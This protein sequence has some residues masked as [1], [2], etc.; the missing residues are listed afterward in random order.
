MRQREGDGMLTIPLEKLAFIVEKA[1]EFDVEVE[2]ET[3]DEASDPADDRAGATAALQDVPDNPAE[4]ELADAIDGLNVDERLD[5]VALMWIG[6]GD[7][8]AEEWDQAR[9]QAAERAETPTSR[10]LAG[11]PMLADHLEEGLEE[12][13]YAVEDIAPE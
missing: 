5:V 4:Q 9:A 11:T 8:D 2:P 12:I 6:R 1:R 10:Y 3:Q 7:F 13:G